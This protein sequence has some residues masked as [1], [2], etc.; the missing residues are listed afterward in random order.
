MGDI[1]KVS[2]IKHPSNERLIVIHQWQLDF[3]E[4][5]ITQT[6][7]LSFFEYWHNVKLELCAKKKAQG[8]SECYRVSFSSAPH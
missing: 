7:L 4:G 1:M 2:C 6:A 5:N 3:C 8:K